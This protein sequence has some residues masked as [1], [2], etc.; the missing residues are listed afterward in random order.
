MV[1]NIGEDVEAP[2]H[3]TLGKVLGDRVNSAPLGTAD[4][5]CETVDHC[6]FSRLVFSLIV[7][8]KDSF[9]HSLLAPL[10]L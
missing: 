6:Q 2:P 1:F 3:A 8:E 9:S 4:H 10:I 5:P 7:L